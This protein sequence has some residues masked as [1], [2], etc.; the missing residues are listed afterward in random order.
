MTNEAIKVVIYSSGRSSG[1]TRTES[2]KTSIFK[3][4]AA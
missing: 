4:T 1:E 2:D 3:P